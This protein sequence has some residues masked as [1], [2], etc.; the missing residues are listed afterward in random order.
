MFHWYY[1]QKFSQKSSGSGEEVD[2]V[3]FAI[4]SNSSH[5]GYSAWPNFTILRPCSQVMLHVKIRE[6]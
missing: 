5:L 3:I 6:L 1:L 4:F 2:F